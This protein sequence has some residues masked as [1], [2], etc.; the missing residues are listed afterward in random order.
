LTLASDAVVLSLYY[1]WSLEEVKAVLREVFRLQPRTQV[2]GQQLE[3]SPHT[4][5][6]SDKHEG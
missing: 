1:E 5:T 3:R 4:A 2:S 6:E